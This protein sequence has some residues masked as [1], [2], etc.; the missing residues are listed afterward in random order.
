MGVKTYLSR[1]PRRMPSPAQLTR[2]RACGPTAGRGLARHSATASRRRGLLYIRRKVN[3]E[4]EKEAGTQKDEGHPAGC[5]GPDVT[6]FMA[7]IPM[8]FEI[9]DIA[10]LRFHHTPKHFAHPR[11]AA[12]ILTGIPCTLQ[13]V[14]DTTFI[15]G[16]DSIVC[17]DDSETYPT[18]ATA[19]IN[20]H[21]CACSEDFKRIGYSKHNLEP[22]SEAPL[23]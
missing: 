10:P 21:P 6:A 16:A 2:R 4:R 23:H 1:D 17:K 3:K 12:C 13:P 14:R 19:T 8:I 15:H 20:I 11:P 18:N 7:H 5:H 22:S 9:K